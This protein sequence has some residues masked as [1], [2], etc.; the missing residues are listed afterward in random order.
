MIEMRR[1]GSHACIV[2]SGRFGYRKYGVPLSGAMDLHSLYRAN[3][4]LHDRIKNAGLELYQSGHEIIFHKSTWFSLSGGEAEITLDE[5]RIYGD[6]SYYAKENSVLTIGAM[7]KGARIYLAI[8]G[9]LDTA[10]I[11]NSRSA[12]PGYLPRT[13]SPG[14][15]VPFFPI[16]LTEEPSA[17]PKAISIDCK[18][19]IT[20]YL[21]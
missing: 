12:I 18:K 4:L 9:G 11:M 2:D 10:V 5:N 6:K 15:K 1:T 7:T 17:A 21:N 3:A 20:C 13:L 8:K 14:D 16:D 19:E